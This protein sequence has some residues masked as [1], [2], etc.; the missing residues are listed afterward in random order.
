MQKKS[1]FFP[2]FLPNKRPLEVDSSFKRLVIEE[3]DERAKN[4]EEK[5]KKVKLCF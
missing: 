4:G 2:S 1:E 3:E 5:R